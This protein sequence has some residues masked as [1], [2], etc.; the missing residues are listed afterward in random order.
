MRTYTGIDS[1]L[2]LSMPRNP[3]TLFICLFSNNSFV[4]LSKYKIQRG[5][6]KNNRKLERREEKRKKMV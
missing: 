6:Q 4:G 2:L 1:D 3:Y 5:I